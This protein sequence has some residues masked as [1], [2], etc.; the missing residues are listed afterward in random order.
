MITLTQ[1]TLWTSQVKM[2]CHDSTEQCRQVDR[3]VCKS[4]PQH[5][6]PMSIVCMVAEVRRG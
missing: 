4:K 5:A 3:I 1:G 6:P 2:Q